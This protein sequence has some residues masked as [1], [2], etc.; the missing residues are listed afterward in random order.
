MTI[1]ASEQSQKEDFAVRISAQ[2]VRLRPH[3]RLRMLLDHFSH[4]HHLHHVHHN[5][6]RLCG[7]FCAVAQGGFCVYKAFSSRESHSGRKGERGPS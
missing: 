5:M 1:W 6:W 7:P 4:L 2:W 3:Q